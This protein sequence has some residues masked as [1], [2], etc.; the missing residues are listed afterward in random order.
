LSDAELTARAKQRTELRIK[1]PGICAHSFEL[2]LDIVIRE[3]VG[4]DLKNS[5]PTADTAG[6]F[7][8]PEAVIV[9]I[10]EQGQRTLHGH[11]LV[12]AKAYRERREQL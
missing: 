2:A 4:W 10:E 1:Y 3:V 5:C 7:G 8:I 9:A 11:I 6:L 12:A